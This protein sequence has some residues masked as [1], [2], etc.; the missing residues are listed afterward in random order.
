MTE[1]QPKFPKLLFFRFITGQLLLALPVL[2]I[3]AYFARRYIL[4]HAPD[5][6]PE[7][8]LLFYKAFFF[9]AAVMIVVFIII[10]LWMGYRL[11]FPLG[12]ALRKARSILSREYTS[13]QARLQ[14]L[15]L[16]KDEAGEWLDLETTLN[17]IEENMLT[18][19]LSL[20]KERGELEAIIT[21]IS[22]AVIAVDIHG[23]SL[24][25]N[26]PFAVLF[27]PRDKVAYAPKRLTDFV[28][29]PEVVEAFEATIQDGN[30]RKV[31]ALIPLRHD[32][33]TRHF[34]L[35]I[36]PIREM[37]GKT[38]GAVGVFHDVDEL[39]RM[40]QIRIDFVANVSHELRTP[41][42]AIKGYAQT[43]QEEIVN[44]GMVVAEKSVATISRNTNRLI[45]L[46][47]DLLNLSSLES[48]AAIHNERFDLK[49][50]TERVLAQLD[51]RRADKQQKIVTKFLTASL[52]A[53]AHRVEQVIYN[54]V[55][56]AIK[57]VPKDKTIEIIWEKEGDSVILRVVDDGPGIPKEHHE[58]LFERFYRVDSARTRDLGGT[59]LGLAIVKHVM[60]R[61]NGTIKV[62]TSAH[63]GTEFICHFPQTKS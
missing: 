43:L 16:G 48:G 50:L 53:D 42:T 58:R 7:V 33:I 35:S 5:A 56:N 46:V 30:R 52:F 62:Q 4:N 54:L 31:N 39:K 29:N 6:S 10:S 32:R 57:Y 44:K 18:Q 28:R 49:E 55:D 61:H 40:E 19:N 8:M 63:G 60:Q 17:Q 2:A 38:I 15:E 14:D 13:Q 24:F 47:Q 3:T 22:D 1:G 34:S 41:L 27:G 12:R 36:A 9:V 21:A 25:F 59:G 37:Q 20:L 23:E 51:A 45:E 11:V 26:S